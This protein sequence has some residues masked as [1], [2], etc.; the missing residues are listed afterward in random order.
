MQSFV[1]EAILGFFLMLVIIDVAL[2]DQKSFAG[3]AIGSALAFL[4]M[5][6]G[7]I[8]GGFV[9]PARSLGPA[10]A[11]G[12]FEHLWIYLI[13]PV[14]GA[15]GAVPVYKTVIRSDKKITQH[16]LDFSS[17]IVQKDSIL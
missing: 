10:V 3:L 17:M 5:F 4:I 8:C 6:A 11:S 15:L 13:A 12:H 1:L 14:L 9:N 7:P 2:G 16:D